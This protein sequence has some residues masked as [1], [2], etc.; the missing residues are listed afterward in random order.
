M[1]TMIGKRP[2]L[3]LAAL[4][5]SITFLAAACGTGTDTGVG[6]AA[7]PAPAQ[8]TDATTSTTTGGGSPDPTETTSGAETAA[9]NLFPDLDVTLIADGSTINLA[10]E[11]GGGDRPVLL[12][13]WAPH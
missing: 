2:R 9:A 13:F 1:H 3:G 12:W 11:L 5:G 8:S 7:T 4:A 6:T 10:D